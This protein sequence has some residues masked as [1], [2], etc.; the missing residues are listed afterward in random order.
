MSTYSDSTYENRHTTTLYSAET[1][2]SILLEVVPTIRSAVDVGCGVGTWLAVLNEKGVDEIQGIDGDWVDKDY[3]VIPPGRFMEC[4]FSKPI[5]LDRRFDL[6]ISLEVAEHLPA[7]NAT[8][9]VCSLTDLSDIVLFSAAIPYQGGNNHIN[10]QWPDYWAR[11]FKDRGYSV[12]DII[13]KQVW[14]DEKIPV[15]YR[16][17]VLLFVKRKSDLQME[18][19]SAEDLWDIPLSIV[20]PHLYLRKIKHNISVR[21]S[22]GLFRRAIENAIKRKLGFRQENNS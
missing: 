6:A 18:K 4:D 13:R 1:I 21:G 3:L 9:F 11:H 14:K 12:V 19:V 5:K 10:E 2:I 16:Q 20:H 8:S 22:L 15:W 17:N 7:T